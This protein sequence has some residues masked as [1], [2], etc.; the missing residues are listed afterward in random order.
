MYFKSAYGDQLSKQKDAF[1]S[2]SGDGAVSHPGVR[3]TS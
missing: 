3:L 1:R 2:E